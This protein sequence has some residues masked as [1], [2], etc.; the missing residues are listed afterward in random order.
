MFVKETQPNM[1]TISLNRTK[2]WK[3][4]HYDQFLTT[5][6]MMIPVQGNYQN[7]TWNRLV[8]NYPQMLEIVANSSANIQGPVNVT[9]LQTIPSNVTIVYALYFSYQQQALTTVELSLILVPKDFNEALLLNLTKKMEGMAVNMV[10]DKEK[11]YKPTNTRTNV[12]CSNCPQDS[13]INQVECVQAV[14][15]KS[16]Q[17]GQ[18]PIQHLDEHDTKGQFDPIIRTSNL[19]PV[20]GLLPSMR[21]DSVGQPNGVPIMEASVPF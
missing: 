20:M 9:P 21:Y 6:A 18:G 14:L 7:L 11:K 2:V 4:C 3:E 19:G 16:Q 1:I 5:D 15:T 12:W 10:K 8:D 17:K 13:L